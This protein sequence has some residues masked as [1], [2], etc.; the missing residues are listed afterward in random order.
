MKT[1]HKYFKKWFIKESTL[2]MLKWS[3]TFGE[4]KFDELIWWKQIGY[5]LL[6]TLIKLIGDVILSST[7]A[8]VFAI[9]FTVASF[10]GVPSESTIEL[11]NS[12]RIEY[13]SYIETD[14]LIYYIYS[15]TIFLI[16]FGF[17]NITITV[18]QNLIS[19]IYFGIRSILNK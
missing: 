2:G 18:V 5:F 14:W 15:F 8:I 19:F 12:T 4:L 10:W 11:V 16:I 6:T 13:L 9:I 7:T 17:I 3:K 1:I